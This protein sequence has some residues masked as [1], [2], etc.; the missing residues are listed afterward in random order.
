MLYDFVFASAR[1]LHSVSRNV[2]SVSRN[3]RSLT[4]NLRSVSRNG[5]YG[6]A[7]IQLLLSKSKN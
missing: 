2:R 3:V 1:N 5:D 4:R 6:C 7:K